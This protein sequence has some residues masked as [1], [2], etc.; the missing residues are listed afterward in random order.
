MSVVVQA[1]QE[2]E[3]KKSSTA[4]FL[5]KLHS[6]TTN[7][8]RSRREWLSF[9]VDKM[10]IVCILNVRSASNSYENCVNLAEEYSNLR[11]TDVQFHVMGS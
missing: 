9:L 4:A 3:G 8:I 11:A 7:F 10:M 1:K 6:N 2:T 5:K